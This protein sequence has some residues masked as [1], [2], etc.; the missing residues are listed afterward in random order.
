MVWVGV[1]CVLWGGGRGGGHFTCRFGAHKHT[2]AYTLVFKIN[3]DLKLGNLFL[4]KH[5]RIKV[6]HTTACLPHLGTGTHP[7]ATQ[8]THRKPAHNTTPPPFHT[9]NQRWATWAWPRACRARGSGRRPCAG[10]PTTSRP[11]SS[12]ARARR[13]GGGTASRSVLAC[14]WNLGN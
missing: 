5:M 3:R 14:V 10:R 7:P 11:K 1:V 13:A 4:D 6:R 8:L 12:R 2:H 9:P